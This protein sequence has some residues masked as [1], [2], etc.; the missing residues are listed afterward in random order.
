ML[1]PT[2]PP[3]LLFFLSIFFLLSSLPSFSYPR[4]KF[5]SA[6][7]M[8]E[9]TYLLAFPSRQSPEVQ[10]SEDPVDE[11]PLLW[12]GRRETADTAHEGQGPPPGVE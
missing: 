7:E 8:R 11:N 6:S 10:R 3:S 2:P 4:D 5:E 12:T 9:K 1:G